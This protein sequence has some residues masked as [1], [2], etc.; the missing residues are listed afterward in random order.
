MD[1]IRFWRMEGNVNG[2]DDD[3]NERDGRYCQ[4]GSAD[5]DVEDN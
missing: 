4:L 5:K 2:A 3:T 1:V